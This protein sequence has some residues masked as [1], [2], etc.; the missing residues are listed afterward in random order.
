MSPGGH[1][2]RNCTVAGR[3]VLSQDPWPVL[4][5]YWVTRFESLTCCSPPCPPL[6][7]DRVITYLVWYACDLRGC[8]IHP[9]VQIKSF[10]LIPQV[11]LSVSALWKLGTYCLSV[12][13]HSMPRTYY[14]PRHFP[15]PVFHPSPPPTPPPPPQHIPPV[16]IPY[17]VSGRSHPF[18]PWPYIVT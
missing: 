9:D 5:E 17:H 3:V 4:T 16:P 7:L 1:W 6:Q 10:R 14:C 8:N 15:P 13:N 2:F 12:I 11:H 18:P